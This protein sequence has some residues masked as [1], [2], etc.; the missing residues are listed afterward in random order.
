M[1]K[2]STHCGLNWATLSAAATEPSTRQCY[3]PT[4]VAITLKANDEKASGGE[5]IVYTVPGKP[6]ILVKVYKRET[7]ENPVKAQTLRRRIEAMCANGSC[8]GMHGLAWPLMPVYGDAARGKLIGFAMRAC[9][10]VPF[11]SI[12]AGPASVKAKFPSWNRCQLAKTAVNFVRRVRELSEVGVFVNDFNPANFWV[13]EH[14]NVSFIDADS[15]Q[16]TDRS[17]RAMITH[18]FFASHAA[19]ELLANPSALNR[20]R[21]IEQVAFS[22]ALVVFQLLMCGYHPYSY[23]GVQG[24]CGCGSP[25]ENLRVGRCPLG[26]G[27]DCRLPDGWYRLWSYLSGKVKNS[28]ITT[29]R[30]GHSNPPVRTS[31]NDL[32]FALNGLLIT[33][34]KDPDPDRVSLNPTKVK[35][36]QWIQTP[37]P[38]YPSRGFLRPQNYPRGPYKRP[39]GGYEQRGLF[40]V[41]QY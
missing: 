20:P 36:R 24:G 35:S 1:S 9:K 30:D 28:L 13:D 16:L 23:Q 37:P 8:K 14:C 25:D 31:L 5:G 4:G 15:F 26:I 19:P 39:G 11:S 7:L 41:G 17:G 2:S 12:F 33:M 27:A 40:A 34:A 18:T 22:T 29:F 38:V 10:G 3:D 6:G 21:T 32:E